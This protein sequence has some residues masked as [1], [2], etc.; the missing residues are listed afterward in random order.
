M[1]V[2]AILVFLISEVTFLD[3]AEQQP[4]TQDRE[5]SLFGLSG[6]LRRPL[7]AARQCTAC[8]YQRRGI[9]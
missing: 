3:H 8:P 2:H 1:M 7:L 4:E 9:L 6:N 5:Q